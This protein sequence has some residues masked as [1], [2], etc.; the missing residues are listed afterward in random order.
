M[1]IICFHEQFTLRNEV[2]YMHQLA[3]YVIHFHWLVC[4][5]Q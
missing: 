3:S 5:L 1:H 4:T 2:D